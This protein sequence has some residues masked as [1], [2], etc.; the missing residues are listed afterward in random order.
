MG[1]TAS[2]RNGTWRNW[3]GNVAAR[4]ARER[5]ARLGRRTAAAVRQAAEDGLTV[6]PVG[7]GHSF[8]ATAATDGRAD[9]A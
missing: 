5:H 6:K 4:P 8:T 2:A 7:T 3:A 9:P 1:S